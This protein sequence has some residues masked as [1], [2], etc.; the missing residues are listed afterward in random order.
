MSLKIPDSIDTTPQIAHENDV[1]GGI[2]S[3]LQDRK[4]KSIYDLERD[5]ILK[6][7]ED[8]DTIYKSY[9]AKSNQKEL[10]REKNLI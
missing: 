9:E 1:L 10:V 8:D 5:N 7:T 4:K 2:E 3:Y 6:M